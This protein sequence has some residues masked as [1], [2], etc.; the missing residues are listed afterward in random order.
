MLYIIPMKQY[1]VILTVLIAVPVIALGFFVYDYINPSGMRDISYDIC[2][3]ET[4]YVSGFSPHGRVLD[5]NYKKCSQSLVIDPVYIDTRL[6]QSYKS[7]RVRLVYDRPKGQTPI[8]VGVGIDPDNWLWDFNMN[9][10]SRVTT[11]YEGNIR[12][13]YTVVLDLS[14]A[15]FKNNRYRFIISAPGIEETVGEIVLYQVD[16]AFEKEKMDWDK[17]TDRIFNF[18]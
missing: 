14:K 15:Q 13:T 6:S 4:S 5:I 16:F 9:P 11:D 8:N 2:S 7:V 18:Q 17:F 3:K 10:D 12:E 1:W